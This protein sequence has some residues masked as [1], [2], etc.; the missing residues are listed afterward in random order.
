MIV[1]IRSR[2]DTSASGD[3]IRP[4]PAK[5]RPEPDEPRA[6]Q[7]QPRV[8]G[9]GQPAA[10]AAPA[11]AAPLGSVYAAPFGFVLR[12][13]V[14]R[15]RRSVPVVIEDPDQL[16]AIAR[17]LELV[18]G[19]GGF[20]A[21]ASSSRRVEAHIRLR[22]AHAAS[23][24][25][26][27]RALSGE[28]LD[29]ASDAL[30]GELTLREPLALELPSSAD[31][32]LLV[33]LG[34]SVPADAHLENALYGAA[35]AIAP[36]L[37][38]LAGVTPNVRVT[39]KVIDH[40][41]V[42]CR[43]DTERLIDAALEANGP[44]HAAQLD[45]CAVPR[46]V[47]ALAAGERQR[48]VAAAH[49]GLVASG[50]AAVALALGNA[51]ARVIAEA[52]RHATRNGGRQPLCAWRVIGGDVQGE[53][54]LPLGITTHGRWRA[55]GESA[56][57]VSPQPSPALDIGMLAACIG[58]AASVVALMDA[59]RLRIQEDPD[60]ISREC[61]ARRDRPEAEPPSVASL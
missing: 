30:P 55:T 33:G 5:P 47:A 42:R 14:N 44:L 60:R 57:T 24:A 7:S 10:V 50:V 26:S 34:L 21:Y 39:S 37:S 41:R 17:A 58:M 8:E 19:D 9:L 51:P 29:L 40:F 35:C 46:A 53:L 22:G 32:A 23:A 36:A 20:D 15:A 59:V 13:T 56:S 2:S 52:E 4:E 1:A 38:R 54:E 61:E 3:A 27:I 25:S 6:E 31:D 28:L 45:E 11:S 49:N 43:I 16:D 48:T 18:A 12:A